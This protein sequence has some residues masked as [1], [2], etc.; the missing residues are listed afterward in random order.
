[1]TLIEKTYR[2]TGEVLDVS[3]A[4][5]LVE[6]HL[7]NESLRIASINKVQSKLQPQMKPQTMQPQMKTLTNKDNARVQETR[8]ARAL[9]AFHGQLKK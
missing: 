5:Q 6:D 3:E 8:K 4:L 1:M 7:I 2:E 9:A